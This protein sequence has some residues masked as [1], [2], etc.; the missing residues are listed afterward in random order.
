MKSFELSGKVLSY[1]YNEGERDLSPYSDL[2]YWDTTQ[3]A[4]KTLKDA[5]EKPAAPYPPRRR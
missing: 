3:H 2:Q 1:V 5:T 4:W